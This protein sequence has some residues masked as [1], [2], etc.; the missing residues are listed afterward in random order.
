MT[1]C[2]LG[3]GSNLNSPRRQLHMAFKSLQDMPR[4]YV[5]QISSIYQSTP[6]GVSSLAQPDYFNAVVKI[7]TSLS[8]DNLL[9]YCQQ[10]EKKQKRTRKKHWGSRTIDI[11]ILLYGMCKINQFNLTVPHPEMHR[12]DFVL[13]PLLE[14]SPGATL[15]DGTPIKTLLRKITVP[16][17]LT[18]I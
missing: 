8:P 18:E 2:Y 14:I 6:F 13:I 17:L 7:E 3:L 1:T 9:Y 16:C 11:D 4:T 15:P 10:I 12:R 5:A